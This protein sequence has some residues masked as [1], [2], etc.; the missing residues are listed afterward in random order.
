MKKKNITDIQTPP[1]LLPLFDQV[2]FKNKRIYFGGEFV[3][4]AHVRQLMRAGVEIIVNLY[5]PTETTV[6]AITGVVSDQET[7]GIAPPIGTPISN[8]QIYI[9]DS[10]LGPVP[11]GSIGELYIAGAGLARGYL[12]RAGLTP[13]AGLVRECIGRGIWRDGEKMGTLNM[14]VARIIR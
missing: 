4:H 5:G 10:T 2:A 8:T 11:I 1:S 12:G 7:G 13:L 6:Q 14:S 9:L 3:S